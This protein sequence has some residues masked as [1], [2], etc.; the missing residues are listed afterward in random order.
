MK[1]ANEVNKDVAETMKL[2]SEKGYNL[3]ETYAFF[4]MGL[5]SFYTG[6]LG[7]NAPETVAYLMES[8]H[9]ERLKMVFGDKYNAM[10]RHI[11]K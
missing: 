7:N 4:D 6:M 9:H 11:K 10:K 1:A 8:H 3:P 2:L 5:C